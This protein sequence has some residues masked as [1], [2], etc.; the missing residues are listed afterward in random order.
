MA[1][2]GFGAKMS[3]EVWVK[4]IAKLGTEAPAFLQ[5]QSFTEQGATPGYMADDVKGKD[6]M[7][8]T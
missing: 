4:A 1:L 3:P 5:Q 6:V 8:A 2:H 7:K